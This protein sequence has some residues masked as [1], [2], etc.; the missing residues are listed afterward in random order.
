MKSLILL[1]VCLLP[2]PA[3]AA[4]MSLGDVVVPVADRSTD[5]R[6]EALAAGLDQVL[7]RLIGSRDLSVPGL[8]S[9]RQQP[10]RWATQYRYQQEEDQ[11]LVSATF[12]INGILAALQTAGA[13]VW[14]TTRPDTLVWM[15][16]QRPGS[17]EMLARDSTDPVV[18]ALRQAG[19]ERGLP[20]TLPVMDNEDRQSI[21][22]ADIRGHFDHVMQ[23]ASQRYNTPLTLAAVLYTGARPQIRWRLF[24]GAQ[25]LEQ[26]DINAA[27]EAAAVQELVDQIA[28]R[29]AQM[30]VVR[31]GDG[32]AMTLEVRQVATLAQWH[33]LQSYLQGLTGVSDVR[34]LALAGETLRFTLSFSGEVAQLRQLL[35]LNGDIVACDS[36]GMAV[37]KTDGSDQPEPM[38]ALPSYCWQ[39]R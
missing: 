33:S 13:P 35:A 15:V 28:N 30:Y 23:Q 19:A 12:D 38:P 8:D 7:V 24:R 18:Q 29:L 11:L 25:V 4:S 5:Q 3:L 2:L 1:L 39:S 10:S 32:A 34:L 20:M 21:S 16:L 14:G 9:V 26:G 22:V 17:G 31:S 27:G 36:A 6:T 37:T